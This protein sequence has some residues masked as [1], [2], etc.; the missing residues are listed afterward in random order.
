MPIDPIS[1]AAGASAAISLG[2]LA[3]RSAGIGKGEW[4][5]TAGP[6]NADVRAMTDEYRGGRRRAAYEGARAG[7]QAAG[8]AIARRG[9]GRS[10]AIPVAAGNI[11][12]NLGRELG[13]IE[14]GAAALGSR[15]RGE[16][17]FEYVPSGLEQFG[18]LSGQV[19]SALGPA[20]LLSNAIQGA[21]PDPN[22]TADGG[23]RFRG[24]EGAPNGAPPLSALG[25]PA[26]DSQML[27]GAPPLV[28]T[29]TIYGN[30]TPKQEAQMFGELNLPPLGREDPNVLYDPWGAY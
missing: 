17:R 23:Y 9:G 2:T 1:I 26:T 11:G 24:G 18:A 10:G 3:L 8:G 22:A 30:L 6:S 21:T 20:A 27:R 19:A 28:P 7:A 4:E 25:P 14:E 29:R 12:A 5:R 15:L 16:R 13:T